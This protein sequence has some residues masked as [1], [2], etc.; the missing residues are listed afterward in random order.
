MGP[1][2]GA[3]GRVIACMC[4]G[5]G[6]ARHA[7]NHTSCGSV[8]RAQRDLQAELAP[9]FPCLQP[10][11]VTMRLQRRLLRFEAAALSICCMS[12]ADM[13]PSN[14]L[15]AAGCAASRRVLKTFPMSPASCCR[16]RDPWPAGSIED[17]LSISVKCASFVSLPVQH[18]G[19]HGSTTGSAPTTLAVHVLVHSLSQRSAH[20]RTG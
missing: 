3:T 4:N 19:V 5:G 12:H 7:C 18:K 10:P 16:E 11:C 13:P 14:F 8:L 1:Q 17:L 6:M 9:R 15:A 20:A 2:Y